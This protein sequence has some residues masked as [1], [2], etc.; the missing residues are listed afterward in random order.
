GDQAV[1]EYSRM[2]GLPK[3]HPDREKIKKSLLTYCERDSLAMFIILKELEG[4]IGPEKSKK[5]V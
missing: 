3:G 2:V 5:A 1:L 4:V